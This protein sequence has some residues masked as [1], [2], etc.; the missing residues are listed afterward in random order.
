MGVY[1]STSIIEV[2]PKQWDDFVALSLQGTVF[3]TTSWMDIYEKPYKIYGYCKGGSLLG[4]IAGFVDNGFSSGYLI[5]F[6]VFQGIL[7]ALQDGKYVSIASQQ[8]KVATALIEFLESEYPRVGISN[9]YTFPDIRPFLWQEY[10]P[11]VKYTYIV[12]ISDI[13][14]AWDNLEKDMRWEINRFNLPLRT[15]FEGFYDLYKTTFE[16]KGLD[17]PTDEG[18]IKRLLQSKI[19]TLV[20]QTEHSG[21]LVMMDNKR[22]YYIFGASDATGESA[23][24]LWM[25]FKELHERGIK[26]VDLVGCNGKNVANWKRGFGGILTPYYQVIK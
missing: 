14:K 25:A 21:V 16:R 3:S 6:T 20:F 2:P 10:E 26:E 5:P 15:N 9:H 12:D 18:F 19:S 13:E 8:M 11:V 24:C 7:V 22:A 4:G 23:Y 17:V 1:M